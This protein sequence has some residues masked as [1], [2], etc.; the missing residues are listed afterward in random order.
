MLPLSLL[1]GLAAL[2]LGLGAVAPQPPTA[3]PL[4]AVAAPQP[5]TFFCQYTSS[6][7]RA[8]VLPVAGL[9]DRKIVALEFLLDEECGWGG[10]KRSNI[11]GETDKDMDTPALLGRRE[12]EGDEDLGCLKRVNTQMEGISLDK[13]VCYEADNKPIDAQHGKALGMLKKYLAGTL[14]AKEVPS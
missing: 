1:L 14:G 11:R 3:Q 8:F 7:V 6:N 10:F 13:A 5:P 4:D 9:E 12:R 2:P